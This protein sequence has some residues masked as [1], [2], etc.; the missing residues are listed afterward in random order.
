MQCG[1][2]RKSKAFVKF[3]DRSKACTPQ[4]VHADGC[5]HARENM[6]TNLRQIPRAGSSVVETYGDGDGNEDIIEFGEWQNESLSLLYVTL[7]GILVSG[8]CV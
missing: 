1:S 6:A 8:T 5:L 2:T 7:L 4:L 3:H